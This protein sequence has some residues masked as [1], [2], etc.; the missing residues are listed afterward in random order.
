MKLSI[1][2]QSQDIIQYL[3]WTRYTNKI[4]YVIN[5]ELQNS[6]VRSLHPLLY[7]LYQPEIP[8]PP[9]LLREWI[10]CIH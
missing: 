4:L 5:Y 6:Y 1:E 2:E 9:T 3:T 7:S 10:M 8:F